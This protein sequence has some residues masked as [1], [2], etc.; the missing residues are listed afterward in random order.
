MTGQGQAVLFAAVLYQTLLFTHGGV[1]PGLSMP[2]ETTG[3]VEPTLINHIG[4]NLGRTAGVLMGR[5]QTD[6]GT[7]LHQRGLM[8]RFKHINTQRSL[9]WQRSA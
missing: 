4:Y 5:E 7:R 6:R 8:L 9:S 3:E 1:L 2:Y